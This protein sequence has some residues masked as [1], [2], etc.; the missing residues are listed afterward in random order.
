[1][2]KNIEDV[3]ERIKSLVMSPDRGG[4]FA[5]KIMKKTLLYAA[6][7]IPE[8]ADDIVS[9]DRAM[10]WGYNQELGLFESWDAIGL[11][12]SVKRMEKEGEALLRKGY[13][14]FYEKRDGRVL[15][16]DL[17]AGQYREIEEKPEIIL[18]PSLKDRKKTVLS[19]PGASLIDLGDGVACL[20]FH[21]KMNSIGADT[22][23]MMRDALKEVEEKFEGLVI[24]NQSENFSAGANLMLM[25]FEIQDENWDDIEASVKAFQDALMA[26]KYFEKPV[27]AAPFGM[28]LAGGC[29]VCLSSALVRAAAETYM[30]LVEVGV[31]LI[32]AGG[33]TK[34]ML[35][36]CTEGI[37]LGVDADHFP[38]VRQTF[39]TVAMAKVA[40]SAKEAQKLGF[41]RS[42]DKITINRDH[43]IHDAKRSVL[44][45]VKEGYRPP[46][47]RRNIKVL[48]EKGYALLQIG[49][50]TMREGGY[51]SQY[52][53]HV[54]KKLAY[55]FSGGNL[56]DGSEVTEQYLLDL[57]RE[58]FMS[59][60]GETKTQERMEHMLKTGRPLRN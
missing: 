41:M 49:L 25:L 35:L 28:T 7:K 16:F 50:Y 10:K 32:P 44:H 48:G 17:G 11:K 52:D 53:E 27:V 19:N 33:G 31:G 9:I 39:E 45:L 57:E 54:A 3:G 6:E 42:T 22:I 38:F 59:L 1:M 51:I 23:Q 2:A 21:S 58:A 46:R 60:C 56:P 37:P 20:E 47:P 43:L 15:Y 30:G 5:W 40:T 12:S 26:I 34:E 55:I 18:L 8:I 13:S 36:R 24:G 29:E 4:Q 14:S